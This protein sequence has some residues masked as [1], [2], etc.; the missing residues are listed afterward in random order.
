MCNLLFFIDNKE[1]T[2]PMEIANHFC[3]FFTNIGP[4][5]AKMIPSATSSFRSFLSGSFINSIFLEPTTEFEISEICA[6]FRAGTSAGFD[7]VTIDVV[8]QTIDLIIDPLTHIMNLSLSS[9]IVPEQMKVA[10]VIPLFKSGILTLFTNYR[11][12]SVLPAFSKFLERIVCKHLNSFLNK[13]G[14]KLRPIWSP[15]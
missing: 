2:D 1:I 9:G 12:V 5:L 3:E 14:S 7:Q 13:Q 6:S 4:N 11:P 10:H 8:K 15:M